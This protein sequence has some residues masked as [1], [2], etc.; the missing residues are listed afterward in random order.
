MRQPSYPQIVS[1]LIRRF[2]YRHPRS[3]SSVRHLGGVR[4]GCPLKSGEPG[5]RSSV[6]LLDWLLAG[7]NPDSGPRPDDLRIM[8]AFPC[9]ARPVLQRRLLAMASAAVRQHLPPGSR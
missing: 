1:L 3:F 8:S 7:A 5:S 6:W 2:P 4:A 9:V